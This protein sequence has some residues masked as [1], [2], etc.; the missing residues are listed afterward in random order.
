MSL[1]YFD[2]KSNGKLFQSGASEIPLILATNNIFLLIFGAMEYQPEHLNI[3]NF[4]DVRK[5]Y[6][7]LDDCDFLDRNELKNVDKVADFAAIAIA[8]GKSVLS[9][10]WMGRNRSGLIS[11]AILK[12][13]T[14]LPGDQLIRHIQL[15]RPNAL[16]NEYFQKLLI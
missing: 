6:L 12:K 3:P 15:C 5:F 9:T 13:L 11:G 16:S 10:C 7:P 8:N 1:I 4:E 2:R 14:N